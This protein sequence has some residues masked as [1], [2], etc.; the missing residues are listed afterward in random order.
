[1]FFSGFYFTLESYFSIFILLNT[2]VYPWENP[3]EIS[4]QKTMR[5][6]V[7]Y[8]LYVRSGMEGETCLRERSK[9]ENYDGFVDVVPTLSIVENVHRRNTSVF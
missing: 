9:R 1:M 4:M 6:F 3:W 7:R 5:N 8:N 2:M